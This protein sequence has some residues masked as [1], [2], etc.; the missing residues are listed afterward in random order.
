MRKLTVLSIAFPFAPVG[1]D[2][3]GGAEQVLSRI[4]AAL[5]AGGHR[6]LV[7]ACAGSCTTG[8]LIA[9]LAIEGR[10]TDSHRHHTYAEYRRTIAAVLDRHD[11]DVIHMHGIDFHE[12]LPPPGVP[13]LVTLHLPP[14]WYP[15]GVLRIDRRGTFFNCVSRSQRAACPPSDRLLPEIENGVPVRELEFRCRRRAFAVAL[16]RVCPE[17]NLHV[18]LDAGRIAGTAVLLGGQVFPHEAHELYFHEQI[19]PRLD[20]RR[21]FLGPLSFER[22]RR[23]LSAARCLLLPTLAPETSSLVAMESLACGTPVV[24]FPSGAIPDIVEDGVTGFLVRDVAEMANAIATCDAIDPARCR[25]AA[26]ERFSVK[27]MAE[28]YLDLYQRLAD[29]SAVA[30]RRQRAPLVGVGSIG[31]DRDELFLRR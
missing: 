14:S 2:A 29:L 27:R 26:S 19:V 15:P 8:S 31:R 9:R 7:V 5:V 16:G 23:L 3:V 1:P 22:K 6:S 17:K 18:A 24:A 10:I 13:V 25:A 30:I 12:Y 4:D 21:H 20:G 11:V 28:Q